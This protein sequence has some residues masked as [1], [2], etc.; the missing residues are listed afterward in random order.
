MSFENRREFLGIYVVENANPNGDPLRD[1]EPRM[2][3]LTSRLLV[4]DVRIKRT[5]R[6]QWEREG[7]NVF[8]KIYDSG[9]AKTLEQRYAELI[10]K[11][12]V[13][14]SD[15]K[16]APHILSEKCIDVRLF[17]VTFALKGE[18]FSWTGPVQISW[19]ISMHRVKPEMVQGTAAFASG[20]NSGQRSIRTEWRVPFAMIS[21]YGVAN[22]YA[23]TTTGAT[24]EDIDLLRRAWWLGT[25]NLIT[26]SK[27]G[28]HPL[29]WLEIVY[30]KEYIGLI[31]NLMPYVKLL[32]KDDSQ[33]TEEEGLSL[34]D[35]R[36]V[37]LD[38]SL[39]VE[40]LR[41][42]RE[43]IEKVI[44]IKDEEL[45]V[46]GLQDIEDLLE[47]ISPLELER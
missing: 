34:R 13:E 30:K 19:G 4:S 31:G 15:A 37:K 10:G 1:N 20:Q 46:E 33:I 23:A 22:Q 17:G 42:Y 5:I 44:L 16:R 36:S 32:G 45:K 11:D 7:R 47:R 28:H 40:K 29:L 27:L 39:L 43:H 41:G 24:D 8:I 12:K 18:S 26:R 6:D 3:D 14:K 21:F 35:Y 25:K 38:F 9:N 2:D